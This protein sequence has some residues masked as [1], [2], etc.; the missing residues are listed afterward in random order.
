[1]ES[2]TKKQ[3]SGCLTWLKRLG[4]ALLI[5]LIG[6]SSAGAIWQSFAR[7][8]DLERYPPPG[9]LVAVDGHTMHINCT[10]AGSPTI[11][12]EGGVPEWSI[13][14]QKIQPEI[15][16]ITRV[17]SYDRAGYG[18]SEPGPQPRSVAQEVAELRTLLRNAGE[19]AP[20]VLVAHSLSGPNALL[21]QHDSPEEV[22]GM[23]LI[24][25]WGPKLL[26]PMP[27]DI[28]Q[29][30]PML[31][32]MHLLAPLGVIR[33]LD[34]IV[35]LSDTLQTGHLPVEMQPVYRATYSDGEMWATMNAEYGAMNTS[36][37]QTKDLGNLKDLPLVVIRAET[38]EVNDYPP[39]AA[40]DANLQNLA[41]L[42]TRGK[43]IVAENSGHFVQLDQPG[44]VIETIED[45]IALS[46]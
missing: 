42:S 17:C 9:K 10:G 35:P 20:Y 27:K 14:W 5:I 6:I 28:E 29:S 21:Y 11:I 37:A 3:K 45:I 26:S 30:L 40:W 8:T 46:R 2:P 44:L 7:R 22:V 19:S 41:A 1:M 33:L 15:A 13:H 32:T 24:E 39:D 38:R 12:L 31:Q 36:A 25:T 23:V 34:H 4:L 16:H 18:W 43:F